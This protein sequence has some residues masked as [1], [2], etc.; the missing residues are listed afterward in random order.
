M[1]LQDLT[2]QLL[3]GRA[4]P[5]TVGVFYIDILVMVPMIIVTVVTLNHA[6]GSTSFWEIDK[7]DSLSHRSACTAA[8][9]LKGP[10]C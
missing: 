1:Q 6:M 5:D 3:A 9:M 10:V 4:L 7:S 8:V 2:V